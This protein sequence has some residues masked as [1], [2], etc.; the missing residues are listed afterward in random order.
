MSVEDVPITITLNIASLI[1]VG[2]G[3]SGQQKITDPTNTIAFSATH[4]QCGLST[5]IEYKVTYSPPSSTLNL[6]SLILPA[7]H[8]TPKIVFAQSTD[9]SDAK[10]YTVTVE[11]GP[12][13]TAS[14]TWTSNPGT[15]T[16]TYVNPC[17]TTTFLTSLTILPMTTSVLV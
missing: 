12:A 6:I 10:V 4:R 16:Y 8:L 11:A 9:I 17:L 1:N 14:S 7:P 15:F 13:G 3:G 2:S 5:S